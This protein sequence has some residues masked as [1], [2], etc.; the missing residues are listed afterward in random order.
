MVDELL[1][2]LLEELDEDPELEVELEGEVVVELEELLDE[3]DDGD[4][5]VVPVVVVDELEVETVVQ[6]I[7]FASVWATPGRRLTPVACRTA[8]ATWDAVAPA[9]TG[10]ATPVAGIVTEQVSSA[11]AVGKA[12]SAISPTRTALARRNTAT[13]FRR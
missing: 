8:A 12:T 6:V 7:S 10:T 2:L 13:N 5:V 4:V 11:A 3:E 1:L 9:G